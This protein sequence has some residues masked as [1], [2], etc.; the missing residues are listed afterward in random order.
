MFRGLHPIVLAAGVAL[1]AGLSQFQP[2]S[3]RTVRAGDQREAKPIAPDLVTAIRDADAQAVRKLIENGADVN[4]RDAEGNTPLILASFYASPKCVALLLEK[5]ADANAANKAGVTALIRAATNYE[6]TRLLVDA[7][8]KVRVRTADLGNTPLILAARRAGNSRTV[9]LLLEHG[10][11]ATE[12]NNAGISPIISGAASGDLETVRFLL[13]A[14]AK[15]DDFPKSND[16]RATDIAAGFRTPLMWAAYHNDVRDGSPLARTRC[17]SESV[18]LFRQ[19]VVARLLE[20]RLRGGRIVDRPR[21]E[22]Q[23]QGRGGGLHALALGG[24][25]RNAPPPSGQAA[26]GERRRSE[27]GGRRIRGRAWDWCRRPRG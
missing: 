4:A 9:K 2:F 21:R 10:A 22:R 27:C 17:R 26:A 13:D 20:R 24:G 12:R 11:D 5:G 1:V 14:G 18:D 15:A 7:G 6:K 23:R 3:P 25:K 8:A 19:P 16:P